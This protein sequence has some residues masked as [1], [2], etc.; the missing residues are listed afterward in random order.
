[1]HRMCGLIGLVL[2]VVLGPGSSS[3]WCQQPELVSINDLGTH[4][5]NNISGSIGAS[6][7]SPGIGDEG[8]W[9]VFESRATDLVGI[10]DA[11]GTL[12]DVFARDMLTHE[13]WAVS[14]NLV[15][16][17][18][19]NMGSGSP[20]ISANGRWVAF[21]SSANDLVT[22]DTS[23]GVNIFLHDLAGR[24]TQLVSVATN[25]TD[26]GNGASS[27]PI[28]SPVGDWVVFESEATT[29]VTLS[30]TNN[31]KDLFAWNRDTGEVSLITTNHQGTAA[32]SGS[33]GSFQ[34][35][36]SDG[37]GISARLAF[38]S[39]FTDLVSGD[40]NSNQDIFTR[41]LPIGQTS[42]VSG[43]GASGWS[44]Q[45]LISSGGD[46]IAFTSDT[47]D[48]VANDNNGR[49]DC[50]LNDGAGI[51][52][53]S[54]NAAGTESANMFST[55][56][57]VNADRGF[58]V[59][60]SPATDL[61]ATDSNGE[62]DIFIREVRPGLTSLVTAN[63]SGTDSANGPSIARWSST[64][65]RSGRFVVFESF[66]TDLEG[67]NSDTAVDV[68]VRDH[69]LGTT[70]L[71]NPNL[72]GTGSGNF[73]SDNARISRNG[74]WVTFSSR[75]SDLSSIDNNGWID[76]FRSEVPNWGDW[77]CGSLDIFSDGFETG[78]TTR[79]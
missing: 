60:R 65:S 72:G 53:I 1:M 47:P 29:L 15:G 4:S 14:R 16:D 66:A 9:V 21:E 49:E 35:V 69:C 20:V 36:L 42:L 78:D 59:F 25:G 33:P 77:G 37:V 31:E 3:I 74:R 54:R 64:I 73:E 27:K 8:R 19:G 2:V 34:P 30:D 41:L 44:S 75:A 12:V 50:F 24:T 38:A 56:T 43:I 48:L 40:T 11:N 28:I 55:C 58:V 79:W 39:T 7:K 67:T 13:T 5:G 57:A 26:G 63:E 51:I 71:M 6:T 52:L 62:G 45:P 61:V 46:W 32:A 23:G 68:Y 76:T 10:T 70:Y 22:Q 18:T 17:A